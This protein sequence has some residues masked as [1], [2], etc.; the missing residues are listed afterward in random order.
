V[1]VTKYVAETLNKLIQALRPTFWCSL[2]VKT[3][4]TP[5]I[6]VGLATAVWA[7][8]SWVRITAGWRYFYSPKFQTGSGVHT[9]SYSMGTGVV[10]RG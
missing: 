5:N 2:T 4:T 10:S 1:T 6:A 9:A 7:G 3:V 8:W